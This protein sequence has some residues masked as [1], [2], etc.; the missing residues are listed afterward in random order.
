V[1]PRGTSTATLSLS[2]GKVIRERVDI[3]IGQVVEGRH[4][5]IGFVG[6]GVPD[7]LDYILA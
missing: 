1:T 3:L 5:G 6:F 7:L 4:C 2:A